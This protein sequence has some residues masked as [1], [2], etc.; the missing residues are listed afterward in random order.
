MAQQSEDIKISFKTREHWQK[1]PIN[2]N[3]HGM[4]WIQVAKNSPY[5]ITDKGDDWTP[6]GQND[7]ITWPELRGAFLRK[8]LSGVEFYLRMLA[9]HG[10]TCLRLMLEYCHGEHR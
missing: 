10:V 8:D 9:Q 6:V 7:A 4:P 1:Y 5:F 2:N 3:G